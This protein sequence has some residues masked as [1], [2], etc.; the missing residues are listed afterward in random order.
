MLCAPRASHPSTQD[1]TSH[2]LSIHCVELP[3]DELLGVL[4]QC[5]FLEDIVVPV[6][7]PQTSS[8][9]SQQRITLPRLQSASLIF[10]PYLPEIQVFAYLKLPKLTSLYVLSASG[11][12]YSSPEELRE[13]LSE[14]GCSL[15]ELRIDCAGMPPLTLHGVLS[16]TFPLLRG[17]ENLEV[18]RFFLCQPHSIFQPL[19]AGI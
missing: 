3:L 2:L 1:S 18:T 8:G 17:V 5:P 19:D 6:L 12:F 11:N 13:P 7:G 4:A 16:P 9:L 14:S 10:N 15:T